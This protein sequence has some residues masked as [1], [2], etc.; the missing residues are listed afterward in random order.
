MTLSIIFYNNFYIL[1]LC[2]I[3]AD[4]HG[5]ING[6]KRLYEIVQHINKKSESDPCTRLS[7]IFHLL[8]SKGIRRN[9]P[10]LVEINEVVKS[11]SEGEKA[12]VTEQLFSR[13]VT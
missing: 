2:I 3:A 11:L 12:I 5:Y 9:D 10:R 13:Y 6:I 8:E 4:S 1:T 7:D